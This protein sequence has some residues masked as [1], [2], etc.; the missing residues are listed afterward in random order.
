M[1]PT[2]LAGILAF[3]AAAQTPTEPPLLIQLIRTPG[4]D[5]RA[6]RPYPDAGAAV[7]VFGM[8]SITGGPEIWQ[9]ETHDSFGGIEALDRAISSV[10]PASDRRDRSQ[11]DVLAPSRTL[12]ALYREDWSFRP[13]VAIKMFPRARYL[14]V[15]IH[16]IRPGAELNYAELVR[17]RRLSLDR[18]NLEMPDIAYQ[19]IS[20][21][22]SGTYVFLAPLTSLRTIDD[23]LARGRVGAEPATGHG[24]KTSQIVAATEIMRENLLFRIEPRIS[25]V[26]DDFASADAEFWRPKPREQQAP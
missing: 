13:D 8:T 22:P 16:R 3:C 21:A 25:Y 14:Y 17:I 26:S 9:I 2:L 24:E 7:N 11:D 4:T 19:V 18:I 6:V 10:T 1:K 15:S 23:G 5:A 12:I 20:G